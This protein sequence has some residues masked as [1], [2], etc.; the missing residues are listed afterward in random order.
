M[1]PENYIREKIYKNPLR[2]KQTK[3]NE[4]KLAFLN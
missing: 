1:I 4:L 3:S 2:D